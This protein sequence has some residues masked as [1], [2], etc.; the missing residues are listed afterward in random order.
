MQAQWRRRYL[1]GQG[2]SIQEFVLQ[3]EDPSHFV[4]FT[5]SDHTQE[6]LIIQTVLR[7]PH[8]TFHQRHARSH[9]STLLWMEHQQDMEKSRCSKIWLLTSA[10]T[11]QLIKLCLKCELAHL[12]EEVTNG[13]WGAFVFLRSES[14]PQASSRIRWSILGEKVCCLCLWRCVFE[15]YVAVCSV[16]A[17][18]TTGCGNASFFCLRD[19]LVAH[20]LGSHLFDGEE[21]LGG[22]DDCRCENTSAHLCLAAKLVVIDGCGV[23][24][25]CCLWEGHVVFCHIFEGRAFS[26]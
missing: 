2:C 16:C 7:F 19:L 8:A 1:I 15:R 24:S 14:G 10:K 18:R 22:T 11:L 23:M 26:D 25:P 9:L 3:I 5:D 12:L 6:H 20:A 17:T 4:V 13:L 21:V